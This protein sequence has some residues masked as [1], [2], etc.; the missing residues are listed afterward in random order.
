VEEDTTNSSVQFAVAATDPSSPPLPTVPEVAT[1]AIPAALA[2]P[3]GTALMRG[4]QRAGTPRQH[5]VTGPGTATTDA[6]D[7]VNGISVGVNGLVLA[8][9]AKLI[10]GIGAF[11]FAQ[12]SDYAPP[13]K[14]CALKAS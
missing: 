9:Q 13:N 5:P 3:D 7:N 8:Y 10:V 14:I 2:F 1:A 4:R 11:G 6:I 12:R